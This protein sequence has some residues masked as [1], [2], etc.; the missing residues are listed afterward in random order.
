[1]KIFYWQ[2]MLIR[3]NAS[4]L[5]LRL[6]Q[7]Q[8]NSVYSMNIGVELLGSYLKGFTFVIPDFIRDPDTL[9]SPALAR[10]R[11]IIESGV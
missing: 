10:E 8:T 4:N 3:N 1:M 7:I 9:F 6:G 5:I 2:V 11:A